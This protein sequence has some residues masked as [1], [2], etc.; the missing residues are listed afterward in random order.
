LRFA[1]SI[2][3]VKLQLPSESSGITVILSKK[4]WYNAVTP[5]YTT[6]EGTAVNNRSGGKVHC[7][8]GNCC[9]DFVARCPS[10]CQPVLKSSIGPHSFFNFQ[11]TPKHVLLHKLIDQ[12]AQLVLKQRYPLLYSRTYG[13]RTRTR[14]WGPTPRTKTCKL[15]FE[16]KDKDFPPGQ[17]HW[18]TVKNG[19]L[20][21]IYQ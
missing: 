5:D 9:W 15:V 2:M 10:C 11:K 18:V 3:L 4:Q 13:S 8:R 16:D 21:G 7:M 17:Q 6:W 19:L 14:T 1:F 20:A 12:I